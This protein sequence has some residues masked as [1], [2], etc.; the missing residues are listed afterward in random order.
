VREGAEFVTNKRLAATV[1]A[2][3]V[4]SEILATL[5]HGFVLA[6]DYGPFY[7]K[8]LRSEPGAPMLLLPVAHLSFVVALVWVFGRLGLQGG[9]IAQGVKLGIIGW[10]LGQAPLWLLWYAEQPWPGTLVLKQLLL[11]LASSL[12]VG[13]TIVAVSGQRQSTVSGERQLTMM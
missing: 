12:I 10:L 9:V 13:V 1:V 4:V 8:L 7:G 6:P 11:E 2:A 3:L 5:V